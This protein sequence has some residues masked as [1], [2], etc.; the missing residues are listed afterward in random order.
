MD[1]FHHSPTKEKNWER[2]RKD[3]KFYRPKPRISWIAGVEL[4]SK[5][6]KGATEKIEAR[7][8]HVTGS[9][10]KK[11]DYVLAR[12]EPGSKFD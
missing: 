5:Q 8:G 10:R 7:G 3:E 9:V 6:Q 1:E 2:F 4:E 11:A 12:S